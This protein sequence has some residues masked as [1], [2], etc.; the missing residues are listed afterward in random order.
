[1][2][3]MEHQPS[4]SQLHTCVFRGKTQGRQSFLVV[5]IRIT[6]GLVTFCWVADLVRCTRSAP[7]VSLY[8]QG[9]LIRLFW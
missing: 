5:A 6:S 3:K 8:I 4:E 1:M 9:L 2:L 7:R